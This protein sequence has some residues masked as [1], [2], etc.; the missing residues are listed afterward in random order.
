MSDV[1]RGI[2][3]SESKFEGA[4]NFLSIKKGVHLGR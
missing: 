3:V 1:L 2:T 4:G